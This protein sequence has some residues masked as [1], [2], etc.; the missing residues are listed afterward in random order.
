M[1]MALIT[2]VP[3]ASQGTTLYPESSAYQ[4]ITQSYRLYHQVDFK[5]SP[6]LGHH[7]GGDYRLTYSLG[8]MALNLQGSYLASSWKYVSTPIS[9]A[10]FD[11]SSGGDGVVN[12]TSAQ[13]NL[14]RNDNDPWIRASAELGYSYRGR[15]TPFD[16][17][18]IQSARVSAGYMQ[19][20]DQINNLKFT[21]PTFN[22]E[23]SIWYQLSSKI[24]IGPTI[25]YRFGWARR[26][27]G[28]GLNSDRIP[29]VT[30]ESALGTVFKL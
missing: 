25:G 12:N 11:T 23:C 13:V 9:K 3:S 10:E 15:L 22:V 18:W 17:K 20:T 8:E 5:F 28:N 19:L 7:F 2:F 26:T 27:G 1:L 29:T 21:G 6:S 14:P 24:L 16:R 30:L 4:W